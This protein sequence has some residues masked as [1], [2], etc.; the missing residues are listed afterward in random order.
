MSYER[1]ETYQRTCSTV[2]MTEALL[3]SNHITHKP[4]KSDNVG[5]T[6]IISSRPNA[7]AWGRMDQ[8]RSSVIH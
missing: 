7:L 4:L 1:C 3:R 6:T 5:K 2:G 8:S